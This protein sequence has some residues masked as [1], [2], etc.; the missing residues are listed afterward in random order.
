MLWQDL[1]SAAGPV[2]SPC[3]SISLTYPS[4]SLTLSQNKTLSDPTDPILALQG[5]SWLT[6]TAI[7]LAT[8]TLSVTQYERDG[9]VH[10][11]I[12]Q[13]VTGGI[14]ATSEFRT[15][16]WTMR[17]HQDS[18]FGSLEGKSRFVKLADL[19]PAEGAEE[20]EWLAEG[21]EEDKEA[22][23]VQSWVKN[24]SMGWTAN[25]VSFVLGWA[26]IAEGN[27]DLIVV[28]MG[29]PDR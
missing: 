16:D 25:Q 13:T 20:R 21:W 14:N 6:R 7:G 17:P 2:S 8:V 26:V 27:A 23:M 4:P 3:S 15:L 18:V 19:G 1:P 22:L 29:V 28:D 9:D 5:I 24:E 11:D 10:V 12:G